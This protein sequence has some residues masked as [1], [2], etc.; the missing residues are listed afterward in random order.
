MIWLLAQYFAAVW[1]ARRARVGGLVQRGTH[2]AWD[3][4]SHLGPGIFSRA[5]QRIQEIVP[6]MDWR[7]PEAETDH[8]SRKRWTGPL[9][10]RE[11]LLSGWRDWIGRRK[12]R[13]RGRRNSHHACDIG[14]RGMHIVLKV[15]SSNEYCDGG[16][17]FALVDLN[18]RLS[19]LALQRIAALRERKPVIRTLT[20]RV[21]GCT[22]WPAISPLLPA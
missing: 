10:L 11:K 4:A 16:C 17:E 3:D 7:G 14:R 18:G 20:R 5:G 6:E 9:E 21:T 2:P 13:G 15:T 19:A 22:L 12:P 1:I 8:V